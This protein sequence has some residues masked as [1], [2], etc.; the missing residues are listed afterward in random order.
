[1]DQPEIDVQNPDFRGCNREV[2]CAD[3]ISLLA[4]ATA[5]VHPAGVTWKQPK[6]K[7][8]FRYLQTGSSK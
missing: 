3:T 8:N 2:T 1:M 6:P 5:P 7:L 4:S